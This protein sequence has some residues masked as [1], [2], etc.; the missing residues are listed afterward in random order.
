MTLLLPLIFIG[1]VWIAIIVLN[2]TM[3]LFASDRFPSTAAKIAAYIWLGLLLFGLA[4]EVTMSAHHQPTK[5]D[6]ARLPFWQLFLLH[7]VLVVFLVGW[8]LLTGRPP[9]RRF[10][11]LE[12]G[13]SGEMVMTGIA[14]GVGGWIFT[15]LVAA[16]IAAIL[17]ASGLMPVKP[18]VSPMIGWIVSLAAWKKVMIVLS[19]M[20]IEEA[21][22][23]GWLQKRVGLIASTIL[24]ALAHVGLGQPLLLIGVGVISLVIGFTF[25]RT[26]NLLPGI[27]AHGIFDG[28]QLFVII[29]MVFKVAGL[30]A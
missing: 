21:F 3:H 7:A 12:G 10:L 5:A 24:F 2:E 17:A 30:G 29:P 23:R 16:M 4:A 1:I 13:K 20:T 19:A 6:L 25:Y 11:N 14:V 22:F 8:W 15:L 28:V 18:H 26:K 9:L 27:I